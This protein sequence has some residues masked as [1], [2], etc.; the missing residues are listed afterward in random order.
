[1]SDRCNRPS[2][3]RFFF[4][5]LALVSAIPTIR[6]VQQTYT[7][8]TTTNNNKTNGRNL[9]QAI[10]GTLLE[11]TYHIRGTIAAKNDLTVRKAD[12]LQSCFMGFGYVFFFLVCVLV[13][14]YC[15][16]YCVVLCCTVLYCVVLCGCV[17]LCIYRVYRLFCLQ[18]H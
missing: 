15:V 14:V 7:T 9:L 8:T 12:T 13:C 16:L 4:L 10:G 11:N 2:S 1:M 17:V 3:T 5:C 18:Y 6:A